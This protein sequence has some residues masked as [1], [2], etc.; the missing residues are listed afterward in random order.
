M[1]GKQT[2]KGTAEYGIPGAQK[3]GWLA[4]M[5]VGASQGALCGVTYTAEDF[6]PVYSD[7]V[8]AT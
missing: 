8:A 2:V 6:L 1:P 4:P 3:R 7:S 5:E